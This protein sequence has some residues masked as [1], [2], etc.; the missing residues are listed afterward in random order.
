MN[1]QCP[2]CEKSGTIED[3]KVPEIGI[4]ATCPQCSTRFLIKRQKLDNFKFDFAEDMTNE[5]NRNTPPPESSTSDNKSTKNE[6]DFTQRGRLYAT[7]IE[8][9]L[10]YYLPIFKK[11][12]QESTRSINWNWAAFC[13]AWL[14]CI[15]RR[16]YFAGGAAFLVSFFTI[17]FSNLINIG[18]F[19]DYAIGLSVPIYLG[20]YGNYIYYKKINNTIN[21]HKINSNNMFNYSNLLKQSHRPNKIAFY[22]MYAS[23]AA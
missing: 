23:I 18:A 5:K 7:A 11:L 12:D 15:Y 22:M 16:L 19:F 9:N 10:D 21:E 20:M 2:N 1:F 8:K 6:Y 14:W 4:Y 13:G 17:A 3:S